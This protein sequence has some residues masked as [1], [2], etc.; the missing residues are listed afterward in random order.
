MHG[1]AGDD[2]GIQ[3][4]LDGHLSKAVR[5]ALHPPR[6][7]TVLIKLYLLTLLSYSQR[8]SEEKLRESSKE[9]ANVRDIVLAKLTY[10]K[11]LEILVNG[12]KSLN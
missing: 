5:L 7:S 4:V 8:V 11:I 2:Q 12:T 10:D 6:F 3:R 1:V 9:G